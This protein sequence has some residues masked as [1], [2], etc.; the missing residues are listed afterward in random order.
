MRTM[1]SAIRPYT[2]KNE[3][4]SFELEAAEFTFGMGPRVCLGKDVAVMEL[5]KLL[6]ERRLANM[7]LMGAL[8]TM[9]SLRAN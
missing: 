7:L 1:S 4:R 5:Y 3:I 6:P 8:R 9:G 2:A